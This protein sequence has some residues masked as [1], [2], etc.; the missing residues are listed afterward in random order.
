MN[1]LPRWLTPGLLLG[2]VLAGVSCGGSSSAVRV[3]AASSLTDVL[4]AL[5]EQYRV[6]HPGA[7]FELR[8][9]GSQAL[10]A[11]IEEGAPADVFLSASPLHTERLRAGG[12][13]SQP[14]SIASN[15]LVIAVQDDS[16]LKSPSDLARPG[17]RVAIGAAAVPVGV[18]TREALAA[19]D[20]GLDNGLD[21]AL[22]A[23]ILDNVITED[24]NV[25]VVLSRVVLGEADAVFVYRT[26]LAAAPGLRAI[27]LSDAATAPIATEYRGVLIGEARP[28]AAQFLAFLA[29]PPAQAVLREAGF[30]PAGSVTP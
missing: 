15:E 30:V 25:R 26:D 21:S 18:L 8:F 14:T 7:Q 22:S 2:L 10:A 20:G 9:G 17:V 5:V 16:A 11:Q 4:P 28:G 24:P 12:H 19:L 27:E 13:A 1:G 29:S 3:Y 23:A 6:A